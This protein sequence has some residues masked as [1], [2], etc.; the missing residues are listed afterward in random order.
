MHV[1]I[2]YL[3]E[4]DKNLMNIRDPMQAYVQDKIVKSTI[5]LLATQHLLL[6]VK[7]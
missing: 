1:R 5:I 3:Q 7:M 2:K 6:L 4:N